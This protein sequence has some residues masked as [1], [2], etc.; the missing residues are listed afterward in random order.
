[1]IKFP[2]VIAFIGGIIAAIVDNDSVILR[3]MCNTSC[4]DIDVGGT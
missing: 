1:M 2:I 3:R 4:S